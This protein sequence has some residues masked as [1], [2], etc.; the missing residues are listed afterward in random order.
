MME[1]ST[2]PALPFA[3]GIVLAWLAGV[4]VYLTLFGVGVAAHFGWMELPQSLALAQS[5]W[6]L[7]VCAAMALIEFATDKIPGVDSIWDLVHTLV[8]I[9]AGAF[10]GG[11]ALNT[12]GGEASMTGMVLGAAVATLSHGLKSGTR[13]LI[14]TSPEPASN[15]TAS[16][17]EDGLVVAAFWLAV[18]HPG[19]ALLL[20]VVATLAFIAMIVFL[21]RLMRRVA[22][23]LRSAE[24]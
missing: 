1:I 5:P 12:G 15:W 10:L 6:V 7:G 4:R 19:L 2:D 16:L 21:Y 22:R 13:V 3:L 8:R 18:V 24:A 14:N 23:R 11:I 20:L 17:A 9:P